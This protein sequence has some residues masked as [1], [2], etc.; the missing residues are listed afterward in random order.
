MKIN[1]RKTPK[2]NQPYVFPLVC[3]KLQHNPCMI[4]SWVASY[5]IVSPAKNLQ[6]LGDGS[7]SLL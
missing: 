3:S 6:V 4:L 5:S 1:K 7:L 2:Q